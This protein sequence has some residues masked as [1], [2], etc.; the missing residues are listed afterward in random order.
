MVPT[1]HSG[2]KVSGVTV[3]TVIFAAVARIQSLAQ[4][5]AYVAGAAIKCKRKKGGEE[6]RKETTKIARSNGVCMCDLM[7]LPSC[8]SQRLYGFLATLTV[9]E[10]PVPH[11]LAKIAIKLF[12][13]CQSDRRKMISPCFVL[14]C[15]CACSTQKFPG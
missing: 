9:C 3:A 1:Q 15:L 14:F 10:N 7:I 12:D 2:L 11:T 5:L 6:E 8:S 4:E 13:L